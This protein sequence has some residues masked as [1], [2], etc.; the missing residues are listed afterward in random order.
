MYYAWKAIS[1]TFDIAVD[2]I[3][4]DI[5]YLPVLNQ[6][7]NNPMHKVTEKLMASE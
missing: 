1:K 3:K 5:N 4:L 6:P 7:V 2:E